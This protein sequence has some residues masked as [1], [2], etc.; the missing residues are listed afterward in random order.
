MQARLGAG[1]KHD[2]GFELTKAAEDA[3]RMRGKRTGGGGRV[4]LQKPWF[5]AR[6][7]FRSFRLLPTAFTLR[8]ICLS[9]LGLPG[10]L[11]TL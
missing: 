3:G 7:M 4:T 6:R 8:D 1:E 2:G 10:A 5:A 9:Y 11:Q